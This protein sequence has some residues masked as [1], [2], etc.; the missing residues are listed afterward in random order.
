MLFRLGRTVG[1]SPVILGFF[2][3]CSC[4]ALVFCLL[5]ENRSFT[6]LA[7]LWGGECTA[8]HHNGVSHFAVVA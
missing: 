3:C 5:T 8:D 2:V 4:G 1:F 7:R 6:T